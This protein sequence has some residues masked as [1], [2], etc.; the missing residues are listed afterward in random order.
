[1]LGIQRGRETYE[2]LQP[3]PGGRYSTRIYR[4]FQVFGSTELG[5]GKVDKGFREKRTFELGS[6]DESKFMTDGGEGTKALAG[7]GA[8]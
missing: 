3:Q 7:G 4:M 5:P 8:Q 1:M 6:E 2:S